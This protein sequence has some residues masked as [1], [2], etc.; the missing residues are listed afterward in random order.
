M[1]RLLL[2][3]GTILFL[4]IHSI[5]LPKKEDIIKKAD[6][7]LD[8]MEYEAAV[9]NYM[10]ILPLN[11]QQRDIRKKIGYAY[12]QLNKNDEA[13]K[14]CR[15]ELKLFPDNGDAYNLL[16]YILFKTDRIN[17]NLDFLERLRLQIRRDKKDLNPGLGDFILGMYFKKKKNYA[18]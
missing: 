18:I 8:M 12:F 7:L 1:R 14:F 10:K 13:L 2:I 9:V 17:E 4:T 16:I 5:S 11:P 6:L 3:I 15:Q